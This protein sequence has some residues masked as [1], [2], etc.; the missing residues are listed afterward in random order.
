MSGFDMGLSAMAQDKTL[1]QG[2]GLGY[3]PKKNLN[4]V[5]RF[6]PWPKDGNGKVKR[7]EENL[8]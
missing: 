7:K 5:N 1:G 4:A 6:G 3:G 2:K 8:C